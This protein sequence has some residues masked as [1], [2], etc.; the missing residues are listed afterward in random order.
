ILTLQSR[1]DLI[2]DN[3]WLRGLGLALLVWSPGVLHAIHGEGPCSTPSL[4]DGY[5]VPVQDSYPHGTL[6]KYSC[7]T[8]YK[9]TA[10][11]WWA[12]SQCENG[13]WSDEP[14]CVGETACLR[15]AIPNAIFNYS[16]KHWLEDG[17]M[18]QINCNEGY[19][20]NNP[21]DPLIR[22]TNGIW[23]P[24]LVCQKHPDACGPPPNVPNAVVIHQKYKELF[25]G[26]WSEGP[27]CG[28]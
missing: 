27:N 15:P 9:L 26:S 25:P 10:E 28:H 22:C 18:I 17:S 24:V 5:F 12:T 4:K 3:M 8:G 7:D 19:S 20:L 23:S 2:P 11:G 1:G 14:Q 13:E 6:I 21:T 16:S